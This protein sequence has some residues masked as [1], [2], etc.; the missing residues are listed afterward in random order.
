[1][2]TSR[3]SKQTL[4]DPIYS[5]L[6]IAL[7][8]RL[9]WV[10]YTPALPVSDFVGYNSLAHR[11]VNGLG[12]SST[13]RVP[14]YPLFL[15]ALYALFGDDLLFPKLA[16]AILSTLTCLFTYLIA[17][18]AF[19][20]KVALTA[21]G[22]VA[23]LP[24]HVLYAGLLATESIFTC[25]MLGSTTLFLF[26]LERADRRWL[27]LMASG[28]VLGL[29]ALVRPIALFLPGMWMFFLLWKRYSLPKA[30]LMTLV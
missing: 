25:L 13:Y 23:L 12:Y 18:K 2:N 5:I 27:L 14:G 26:A 17:D 24:S 1:M 22:I 9:G 20:R 19:S 21:S 10:L 15:A 30:I 4:I 11:L 6:V 16:N 8:I 3:L 28:F 7:L 29:A